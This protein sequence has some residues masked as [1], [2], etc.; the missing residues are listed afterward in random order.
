MNCIT[1]GFFRLN[2]TLTFLSSYQPESL[3]GQAVIEGVLMRSPRRL[4]VA[5]RA[6]DGS[7]V[8]D[9]REFLS[10]SRR[11]KLLGLPILRGAASLIESLAI[12]VKAL[13]FSMSVQEK[14]RAK[15][16]ADAYPE[17]ADLMPAP[18]SRP[19]A[20]KADGLWVA[21]SLLSSLALAL[22]L[23][24]LLPYF[25]AGHIVG[26]TQEAPAD[27]VLFNMTAGG[28]R[29]CLLLA[30]MWGISY[31]RDIGRVFQYHGA[32]HKS[33]FVH[34]RRGSLDVASARLQSRFHPRCG[35]SFILIVALVCM[36]F[37][38]A[39][40]GMLWQWFHFA[41]PSFL[42]RFAIH[43]PFVPL[44]AGLSFE[45]LKLT[46]RFQD[47]FWVRPFVLPGLW[48]QKITTREPDEK[49][50][51]VAIASIRAALA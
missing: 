9:N 51:E 23:F 31:L 33:I 48:L 7:I 21:L 19:K 12:G 44:V 18:A 2:W 29:M 15:T 24:Q 14:S 36:L 28:V 50:L 13:N 27:P 25:V 8:V 45:V 11:H 32:E 35:T 46:A 40:D 3:G 17:Y 4:A 6:P 42:A 22:C 16:G 1:K 49:Q 26:G 37:F 38:S 41:Y 30:Y 39:L 5:V 10:Y 43:L 34:E 47:S 20:K